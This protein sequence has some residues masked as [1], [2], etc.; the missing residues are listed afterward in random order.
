MLNDQAKSIR[1][2]TIHG[3][4][5]RFADFLGEQDQSYFDP[6]RELLKHDVELGE[7]ASVDGV[8]GTEADF[9]GTD[10]NLT[11]NKG[12]VIRCQNKDRFKNIQSRN[13]QAGEDIP[14]EIIRYYRVG[15]RI[16]LDLGRDIGQ[17][18]LSHVVVERDRPFIKRELDSLHDSDLLV[19]HP[20]DGKRVKWYKGVKFRVTIPFGKQLGVLWKLKTS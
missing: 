13:K 3:S 5:N 16:A 14:C 2:S 20:H 19:L 10:F 15:S 18:P 11:D 17:I 4:E 8:G 1:V 9:T 12:I 6:V 7:I